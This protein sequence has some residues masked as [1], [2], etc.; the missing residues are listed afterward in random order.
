[1]TEAK[2]KADFFCI[3]SAQRFLPFFL[4]F[5]NNITQAYRGILVL[6]DMLIDS[7]E[8]ANPK[9]LSKIP[10]IYQL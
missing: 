8:I 6:Q 4:I 10:L 9:Q 5:E 3:T 2:I 1:M 7:Q